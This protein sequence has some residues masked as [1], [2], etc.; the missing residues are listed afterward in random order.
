ME[1]ERC[2]LC[3]YDAPM[4]CGCGFESDDY[5][6]DY[7]AIVNGKAVCI[8]LE[9]KNIKPEELGIGKGCGYYL[10]GGRFRDEYPEQS[11][12]LLKNVIISLEYHKK[13]FTY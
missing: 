6:C 3:C 11:R 10:K 2:G 5:G 12:M 7:F 8:G 13:E 1:C 9:T 4:G